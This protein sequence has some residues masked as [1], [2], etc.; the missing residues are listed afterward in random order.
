[1]DS[2]EAAHLQTIKEL[3]DL[4][5]TLWVRF[6]PLGDEKSVFCSYEYTEF[7]YHVRLKFL[8]NNSIKHLIMKTNTFVKIEEYF[9]MFYD[10]ERVQ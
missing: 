1:M 5:G 6:G 4:I 2:G 7:T 3:D 9:R 10:I 8:A